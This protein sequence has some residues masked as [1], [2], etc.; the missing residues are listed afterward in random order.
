MPQDGFASRLWSF[1]V[2][3]VVGF[4]VLNLLAMI[5]AVVLDSVATRWLGTWLPAS[6]TTRCTP[7]P[8]TSSS[9]AMC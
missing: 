1:A 5:A 9:S 6:L 4:F 8:G 7:A 3:T 2:W